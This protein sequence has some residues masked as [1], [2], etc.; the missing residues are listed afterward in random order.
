[1]KYGL[2]FLILAGCL[3]AWPFLLSLGL[4][5]CWLCWWCAL[6]VGLVGVAYLFNWPGIFGKSARGRQHLMA[7][8]VLMPWLLFTWI[9]WWLVQRLSSEPAWHTLSPALFIGRRP[10]KGAAPDHRV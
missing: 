5:L 9:T 2:L 4:W 1:M 3:V 7:R 10:A 8:L 6:A